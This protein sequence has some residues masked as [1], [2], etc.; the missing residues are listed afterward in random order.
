MPVGRFERSMG[1]RT[2]VRDGVRR[3]GSNCRYLGLAGN[4]G[5]LQNVRAAMPFLPISS[6]S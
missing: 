2:T 3:L 5:T 6:L 1:Y 4:T